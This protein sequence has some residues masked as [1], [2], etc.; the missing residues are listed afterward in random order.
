VGLGVPLGTTFTVDAGYVHVDT[1]GRRGRVVERTSESQ[2]A[3]QLNS[4]VYTEDAN[5]FS[6]SV[7]AYF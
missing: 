4:G 1:S 6:L 5:I 7:R 3:A 2:T